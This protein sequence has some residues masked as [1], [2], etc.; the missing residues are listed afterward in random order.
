MRKFLINLRLL[1]KAK[2]SQIYFKV[3]RTEGVCSVQIV[4]LL[5]ADSWYVILGFITKS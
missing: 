3:L 4:K 5:E 1:G 2:Q